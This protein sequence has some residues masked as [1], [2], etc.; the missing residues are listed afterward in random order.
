MSATA[1]VNSV[2]V[3]ILDVLVIDI[4][5]FVVVNKHVLNENGV[6]CSFLQMAM[7]SITHHQPIVSQR[8]YMLRI[9]GEK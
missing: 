7:H 1:T 3:D 6:F 8:H 5:L 2:V 9:S 4:L